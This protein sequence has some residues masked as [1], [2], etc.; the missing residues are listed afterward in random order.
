MGV[1]KKFM[2]FAEAL[3]RHSRTSVENVLETLMATHRAD[4]EL[5][6]EELAELD[7]RLADPNPRY[8]D[9]ANI[10]SL[11]GQPFRK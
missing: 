4:T 8:A 5:T 11:L 9:L 1:L 3:P 10:E 7:R 2:A 6:P